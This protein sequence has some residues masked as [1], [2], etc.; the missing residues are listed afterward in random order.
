MVCDIQTVSLMSIRSAYTKQQMAL[1][2]C[3]CEL[4]A[5]CASAIAD[6]QRH[7]DHM[8]CVTV[9]MQRLQGARHLDIFRISQHTEG[10]VSVWCVHVFIDVGTWGP[11]EPAV[12]RWPAHSGHLLKHSVKQVMP[13]SLSC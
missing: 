9:T 2:V 1:N 6:T 3:I 12:L 8:K 4:H 10:R 11:A 13:L 7:T 5:A